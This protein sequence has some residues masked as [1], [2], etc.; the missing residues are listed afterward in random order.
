MGPS[1][2]ASSGTSP[3]GAAPSRCHA[4]RDDRTGW[5]CHQG[6]PVEFGPLRGAGVPAIAISTGPD[7]TASASASPAPAARG[8]LAASPAGREG[9][10]GG[11][12]VADRA[13]QR[14]VAQQRISHCERAGRTRS[15]SDIRRPVDELLA[16]VGRVVEAARS[17]TESGQR[18]LEQLAGQ[19]YH[20]LPSSAAAPS[21]RSRWP[22]RSAQWLRSRSPPGRLPC[23]PPARREE[24]RAR[25]PVAQVHPDQ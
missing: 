4:D 3:S 18:G 11:V 25:R 16:V 24:V 2:P 9:R 14:R 21:G 6:H 12:A 5:S 7:S 15:V 8:Y 13:G 22:A 1:R 19:R 17:R 10:D 20:R 23:P